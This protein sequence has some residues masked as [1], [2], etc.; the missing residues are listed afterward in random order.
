MTPEEL[1]HLLPVPFQDLL[2]LPDPPSEMDLDTVL[3]IVLE[4]AESM[5]GALSRALANTA[6]DLEPAAYAPAAEL[7]HEL[8]H[9]A[10]EVFRAW[11]MRPGQGTGPQSTPT[12]PEAEEAPDA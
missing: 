9:A 5:A 6:A 10:T 12:T 4:R 2:E 11:N 7:L 1:R 3:P 8:L